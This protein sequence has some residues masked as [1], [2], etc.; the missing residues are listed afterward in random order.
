MGDRLEEMPLFLLDTVLFPYAQLQLH[1]FEDRYREM[2]RHCTQFD[3]PFGIVLIRS[4]SEVGDAEP[5]MVGTAVRIMS[6]HTYEDG[7]MDVRVQGERRFRV[8]RLDYDRPY[9]VGWV[10]SVI[11]LELEDDPRTEAV[12]SRARELVQTYIESYFARFEVRVSKIKL[13]QEPT[14]LS[15]VVANLLQVAN[16]EK[17]RLLETTDTLERFA[18]MIPVLESHIDQVQAPRRVTSDQFAEWIHPN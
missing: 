11:E 2:I 15:F 7:K 4:G 9:T 8:R 5:Y 12:L 1:V 14:T 17:Q 10:E 6:V 16:L 3:R 13:P 18:E